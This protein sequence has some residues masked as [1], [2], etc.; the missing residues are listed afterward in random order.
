MALAGFMTIVI[1]EALRSSRKLDLQSRPHNRFII[2]VMA[3]LQKWN[4]T[5]IQP[6]LAKLKFDK[7]F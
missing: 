3:V 4:S 6:S 1:M 7:L 2:D 5:H